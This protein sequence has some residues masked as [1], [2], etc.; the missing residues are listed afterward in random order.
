MFLCIDKSKGALKGSYENDNRVIAGLISNAIDN[1]FLRPITVSE[2]ISKDYSTKEIVKVKTREEAEQVKEYAADYLRSLRDGFGY[3]MVFAVSEP[4]KAYFTYNG[5]SKYVNPDNDEHDIWYKN[6][7]E[8]KQP[9]LLDVD[10]DEANNWSLSVF[11]NTAVYNDN[12]ELIGVCG[13]GVD[14]Q[15]LQRLLERYERIYDIKIQLVNENG[16][17]QVDTDAS[18]IEVDTVEIENLTSY[19]DGE[20][21]YEILPHGS[22]TITYLDR[23]DWYLIVQNDNV[24]SEQVKGII[25]PCLICLGVCILLSIIVL[26]F[27]MMK[28]KKD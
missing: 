9:Y 11:I 2:T 24:W 18:R 5:I 17:I 28:E 20:Y 22:R 19:S 6:F 7:L 4:S 3:S 1:A 25:F 21:Y 27:G 13:V 15:E 16:L 26:Q 14:M 23:L 10:T 8:A 12:S